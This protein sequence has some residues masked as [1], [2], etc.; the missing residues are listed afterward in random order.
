[1]EEWIERLRKGL[2]WGV[3]LSDYLSG[4]ADAPP[5]RLGLRPQSIFW[6]IWWGLL[7]GVVLI[8]CGQSS[9]FIYIDF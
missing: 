2:L 3:A 7:L 6:G 5:S 4:R 1:M 8:F 9:K